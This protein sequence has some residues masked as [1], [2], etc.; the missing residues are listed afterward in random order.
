MP[1]QWDWPLKAPA[2]A[3]GQ[4]G[5]R[6]PGIPTRKPPGCRSCRRQVETGGDSHAH[7][8]WLHQVPH[9]HVSGHGRAGGQAL[10]HPPDTLSGQ[11]HHLARSQSRISAGRGTGAWR[12]V[13]RTRIT[14]ISSPAPSLGIPVPV[15]QIMVQEHCGF[16]A[17]LRDLRRGGANEGPLRVRPR[18]GGSGHRGECAR[19]GLRRRQSTIQGRGDE[20]PGL[21]A[22]ETPSAGGGAQFLLARCHQRRVAPAGVLRK[23]TPFSWMPARS[24]ARRPTLPVRNA[25]SRTMVWP[26]TRA[27]GECRRWPMPSFRPS[28][29]AAPSP[30]RTSDSTNRHPR[31]LPP[32]CPWP[33]VAA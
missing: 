9:L 1:G 8:V 29:S 19:A 28:C 4:R 10:G 13:P 14:S 33:M 11:Q 3:A 7:S 5:A 16:R 23:R 30:G 17:R 20:D 26:V 27:T 15:P 25:P 21:R 31:C 24:A 32:G 12:P 6:S 18:P 22:G 2:E